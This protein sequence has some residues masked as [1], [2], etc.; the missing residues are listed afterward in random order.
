[1]LWDT[2]LFTKN[3][4]KYTET[5]LIPCNLQEDQWFFPKTLVFHYRLQQ[6]MGALWHPKLWWVV[7]RRY[8]AS[9]GNYQDLMGEMVHNIASVEALARPWSCYGPLSELNPGNYQSLPCIFLYD[10][11]ASSQA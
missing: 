1:M 2:Q 3:I 5:Y 9:F 6:E 10:T 11:L 8:M 4:V 7:Y